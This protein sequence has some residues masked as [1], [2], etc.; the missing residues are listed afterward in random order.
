MGSSRRYAASLD[1]LGR[2]RQA[3]AAMRDHQPLSLTSEELKLGSEWV[4]S[5]AVRARR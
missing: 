3:A 2:E 4:W 1:R 5:S